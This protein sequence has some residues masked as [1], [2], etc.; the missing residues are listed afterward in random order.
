MAP[1]L[2][3]A[4]ARRALRRA[5]L[6]GSAQD[7]RSADR[8]GH[9]P[10]PGRDATRRHELEPALDGPRLRIRTVDRIVPEMRD[11]ERAQDGTEV[12]VWELQTLT[13]RAQNLGDRRDAFE[14]MR[15]LTADAYR[16]ETGDT[17]RPRRGS[18]L[19]PSRAFLAVRPTRRLRA[20]ARRSLDTAADRHASADRRVAAPDTPRRHA[21]PLW[22]SPLR[23]HRPR[24][25]GVL[26]DA[27]PQRLRPAFSPMARP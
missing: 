16:V 1:A 22:P 7:R 15:D 19:I 20:I 26:H 18:T 27:V 10:H 2:C 21:A 6:R 14:K 5:P 8:G 23:A 3:R 17:W 25:L 24:A 9:R 4:R 13:D 12:R 11:L